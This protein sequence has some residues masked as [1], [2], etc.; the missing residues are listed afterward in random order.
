MD[1]EIKVKYGNSAFK[2]QAE[3][4]YQSTQIMRIKVYGNKGHILLENNYPLLQFN[5]SNKA[6]S[7]KVKES[8][9][10]TW[11]NQQ[12]A[13]LIVDIIHLLEDIVKGKN[14][15]SHMEHIKNSKSW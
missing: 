4:V 5:R 13:Q 6:I 12:N 15:L 7:W 1:W 11:G 8:Y 2:L 10:T 9:F 3:K 14:N